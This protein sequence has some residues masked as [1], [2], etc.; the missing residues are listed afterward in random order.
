[1]PRIFKSSADIEHLSKNGSSQLGKGASGRVLLVSHREDPSRRFAMK[2]LLK[3]SHSISKQINREIQLHMKLKNPNVIAM[4]DYLEEGDYVYIFMEYAPHGDLF[5]YI[6]ANKSR[7]SSIDFLR[8]FYE[9]CLGL[10]YIQSKSIIHRD[11]KPENILLGEDFRVKICDFGWSAIYSPEEKRETFC[12]TFE[13]MAPEVFLKRPQTQKTD[14]WSLGIL[15]YELTHGFAPF[16]GSKPEEVMSKIGA[17][18]IFFRKD[19]DQRVRDLIISILR[20]DPAQRPGISTILANSLFDRF[21]Q[22]SLSPDRIAN[23]RAFKKP[24]TP[25]ASSDKTSLKSLVSGLSLNKSPVLETSPS[26]QRTPLVTTKSK[27]PTFSDRAPFQFPPLTA[28]AFLGA[29]KPGPSSS[30]PPAVLKPQVS[31]IPSRG[32]TPTLRIKLDAPKLAESSK[33]PSFNLTTSASK[34]TPSQKLASQ[35]GVYRS[36]SNLSSA[37]S[38]VEKKVEVMTF[39]HY[40]NR[41]NNLNPLPSESA[42]TPTPKT[43]QPDNSYGFYS[44]RNP[45]KS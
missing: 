17:N 29:F 34:P 27:S 39:N 12:G 20:F 25:I 37:A 33:V 30:D 21:R 41:I 28:Q 31:T 4:E 23:S 7:I 45:F 9:T 24:E 35:A 18:Q 13:Y 3:K 32:N 10:Q 19:L 43:T 42:K 5:S 38:P 8:I 36:V 26:T 22:T 1:M 15:L 6:Q 16:R 40:L 44:Q 11:L 14:V 2:A